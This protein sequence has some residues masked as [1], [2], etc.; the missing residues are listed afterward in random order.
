MNAV[1]NAAINWSDCLH[2]TLLRTM[3]QKN[4][5]SICILFDLEVSGVGVNR[6]IKLPD[7]L[8]QKTMPLKTEKVP[9]Q[10]DADQWHHLKDVKLHD[11]NADVEL[12][13]GTDATNVLEL[14]E[15]INNVNDGPYA[16]RTNIVCFINGPQRTG[17]NNSNICAV[18]RANRI[19]V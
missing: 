5:V 8:T 13:S 15:L 1:E 9:G 16:V 14:M 2:F 7:V 19:S 11:I 4:I 17:C 6:F 10:E 18:V 12:L 3:G